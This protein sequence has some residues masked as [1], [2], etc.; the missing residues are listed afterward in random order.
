MY[1][2]GGESALLGIEH[3]EQATLLHDMAMGHLQGHLLHHIIILHVAIDD[4]TNYV[5]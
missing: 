1:E 4:N 3:L 5:E 2:H